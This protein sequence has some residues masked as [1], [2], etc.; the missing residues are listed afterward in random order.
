MNYVHHFTGSSLDT[1]LWTA[2]TSGGGTV[3]VGSGYVECNKAAN[4]DGAAIYLNQQIDK[5][6]NQV[7]AWAI[8][9]TNAVNFGGPTI[10]EKSTA[11][12]CETN[13]NF[14]P[15]VR[16]RMTFSTQSAAPPR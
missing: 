1:A 14:D 5:T 2:I 3:T 10:I 7:F 13:V 8:N 16:M 4:T 15:R 12:V 11:P 6:K 9:Q